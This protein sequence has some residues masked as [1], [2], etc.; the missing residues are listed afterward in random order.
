MLKNLKVGGLN[1]KMLQVALCW[2]LR[3]AAVKQKV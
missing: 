1:P 2:T 3:E